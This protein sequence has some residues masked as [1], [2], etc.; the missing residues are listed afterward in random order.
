[1]YTSSFRYVKKIEDQRYKS[2]TCL[3][4][5]FKLLLLLVLLLYLRVE[6]PE[7]GV[8]AGVVDTRHSNK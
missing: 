1:M 8:L 2:K 4:K 7:A 6:I 5:T 3:F